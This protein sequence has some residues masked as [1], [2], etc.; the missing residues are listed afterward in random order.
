M[1]AIAPKFN[2]RR[3]LPEG[4]SQ[5]RD[6]VLAQS[7]SHHLL[8]SKRISNAVALECLFWKRSATRIFT[9]QR[10]RAWT[11]SIS[12][13]TLEHAR[14]ECRGTPIFLVRGIYSEDFHRLEMGYVLTHLRFCLQGLMCCK[15]HWRSYIKLHRIHK[16]TSKKQIQSA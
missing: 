12:S 6:C 9:S 4:V 14:F 1:S 3:D 8:W 13:P 16:S 10:L 5:A 7:Q 2:S 15:T 11:I